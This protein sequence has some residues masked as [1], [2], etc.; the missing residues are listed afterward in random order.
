MLMTPAATRSRR[1]PTACVLHATCRFP[2][3]PPAVVAHD[4]PAD[5]WP[6][7]GSRCPPA[8]AGR[9]VRSDGRSP[10]RRRVLRGGPDPG[11]RRSL[12]VAADP[13]PAMTT[14]SRTDHARGGATGPA[15]R[16]RAARMSGLRCTAT[17]WILH[18]GSASGRRATPTSPMLSAMVGALPSTV[19]CT[20]RRWHGACSS[21]HSRPSAAT[22]PAGS[23]RWPEW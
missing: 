6:C 3:G 2:F 20:I 19:G 1:R 11:P 21:R 17:T 12:M 8:A 5:R 15:R 13:A 23:A 9:P 10:A 16:F 14:S 22:R 4:I 7:P 18:A